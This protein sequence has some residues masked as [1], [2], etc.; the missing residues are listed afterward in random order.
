MGATETAGGNDPATKSFMET[1]KMHIMAVTL[2]IVI[3]LALVWYFALNGK[4]ATETKKEEAVTNKDEEETTPK[5][6]EVTPERV[7]ALKDK[8]EKI[9]ED[10]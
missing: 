10:Q 6:E 8:I 4:E 9:N 1:Y 3:V 7:S 2:T 5:S